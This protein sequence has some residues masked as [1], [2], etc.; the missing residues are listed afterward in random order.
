MKLGFRTGSAT[1]VDGGNGLTGGT[2]QRRRTKAVRR[3]G[4]ADASNGLNRHANQDALRSSSFLRC[5][6]ET[7]NSAT[8]V[9]SSRA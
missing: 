2:K 6:C 1:E 3:V 7:V 5:S 8:S 9:S 4:E